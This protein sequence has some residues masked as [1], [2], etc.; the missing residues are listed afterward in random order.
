M[1]DIRG[2]TGV[3]TAP[4]FDT[5]VLKRGDAVN[6]IFPNSSRSANGVITYSNP[7]RL[8][9]LVLE[10]SGNDGDTLTIT[11]QDVIDEITVI[12]KLVVIV[13]GRVDL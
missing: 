2:L 11:I 7:L 9:V 4:V 8:G 12:S 13:D 1:K 5:E 3:T 10:E 6:V